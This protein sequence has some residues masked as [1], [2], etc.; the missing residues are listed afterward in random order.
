MIN[1]NNFND[2]YHVIHHYNSQLHWSKLPSEFMKPEIL[3]KHYEKG[4]FTFFGDISFFDVSIY[5]LSGNLRSL[6]EKYYVHIGPEDET[7]TV[8]E[9]VTEAQRR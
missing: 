4:A 1:Q 6:I 2:G 5:V 9:I 8:D 3:A 7:P